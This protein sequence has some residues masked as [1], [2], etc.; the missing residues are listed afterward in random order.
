M[1]LECLEDTCMRWARM[2]P[3]YLWVALPPR[4]SFQAEGKKEKKKTMGLAMVS[5]RFL[6]VDAV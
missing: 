4:L 3:S 2:D 1:G 5:L 6:T